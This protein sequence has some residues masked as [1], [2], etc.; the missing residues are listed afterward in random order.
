GRRR[1]QR[2]C[3]IRR[4]SIRR[5]SIGGEEMALLPYIAAA[6]DRVAALLGYARTA[7]DVGGRWLWPSSGGGWGAWGNGDRGPPGSWQMGTNP[8]HRGSL[9][10][11]AFSACYACI[12]LIASDISKLPVQI[13]EVNLGDGTRRLLRTDYYAQLFREPNAYQTCSDFLL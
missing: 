13:F 6:A 4:P 11:L 7:D 2:I 8:R 5:P 3:P 1:R 12:N 9:E 10:L